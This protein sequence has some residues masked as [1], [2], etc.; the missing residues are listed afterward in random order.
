MNYLH[1]RNRIYNTFPSILH[2]PN[3]RPEDLWFNLIQIAK[4]NHLKIKL[5]DD[6]TLLTF[7]NTPSKM[8]LEIILDGHNVNYTVLGKEITIWKNPLKIK[9]LKDHLKKVK[10]NFVLVLDAEDVIVI[11]TL[12]NIIE[13]FLNFN[14]SVLYNASCFIYPGLCAHTINE[15]RFSKSFFR[16]L[17]SGCFIG[18]TNFCKELY[19]QCDVYE[20]DITRKYHYSDQIKLKAL[21]VQMHPKIKIDDTCEIFQVFHTTMPITNVVEIKYIIPYA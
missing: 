9:L 18:Y 10:T 4:R 15:E 14:C 16:H 7:N 20:D 3:D 11:K 2:C 19:E 17:N 13:Q 8:L 1:V 12:E 5:P 21:Y 6:L